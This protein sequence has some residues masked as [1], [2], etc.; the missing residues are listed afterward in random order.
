MHKILIIEDDADV[1]EMLVSSLR[2]HGFETVEAENGRAGVQLA[3]VYMPDLILS[4]IKMEGFDGFAA[5]A[6]IRYQPLTSAI[7]V[8]LMTGQPDEQG[9]RFAM[10][11]GADDYLAKPFTISTLLA[12]IHIQLKKQE[13]IK[14]RVLNPKT[15]HFEG[16]ADL[17]APE[18]KADAQPGSAPVEQSALPSEVA[19]PRAAARVL[20][21]RTLGGPLSTAQTESETSRD[22]VKVQDVETL[23][24]TYLRMLN[25]FHP[26]LGNTAMRAMPLCRVLAEH[27]KFSPGELQD[28]CWAA[29]LHDISLVGLD[30]EA[31]GRWL[32]NPRKV[33]EE[34]DA[35]IKRHPIDSQQ[36]LEDLPIFQGAGRIIRSH[37]EHW[38]G[39]GYPDGLKQEAIPWPARLLTAA[40]FYCSQHTLGTPALRLL[41]AQA[42][43]TLDPSAVQAVSDAASETPLPK[44]VREILLNEMKP[45]QIVA[46]EIFNSTGMVLV[47]HGR[48]L[49]EGLIQRVIAINRVT[50][51]D[52]NVL[53][54]C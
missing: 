46:K 28:L 8:V 47:R 12:T 9:R 1:R 48:E 54:Y 40:L 3:Q 6:A 19:T 4:D 37:H 50:P 49:T 14:Q 29:G 44:G 2:P 13:T 42:G 36:M 33:T 35:F 5:L 30:R 22:A 17:G 15:A 23:V 26:N 20:T 11:L 32:R 34:E 24:E 51:L 38:D 21:G 18:V 41:R 39:S 7:P 53:V 43:H 10:E 16:L 25:R 52:Q 31:V 27:A 45:G